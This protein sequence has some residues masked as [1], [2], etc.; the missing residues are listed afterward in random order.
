MH[1]KDEKT[2]RKWLV[3]V[4]LRVHPFRMADSAFCLRALRL[5]SVSACQT[6]LPRLFF[7]AFIAQAVLSN[8]V[9]REKQREREDKRGCEGS[10]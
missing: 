4:C 8:R 3:C 5:P 2:G 1:R 7:Y 9:S 10:T 6:R